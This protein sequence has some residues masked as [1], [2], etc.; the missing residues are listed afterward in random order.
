MAVQ[1]AGLSSLKI[2]FGYGVETTAG[3]K[4]ASFK[5]LERCNN[6]GGIELPVETID[7]SALEDEVTKYIAGRQDTGK[8]L[9]A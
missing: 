4:P 7:A 6:I 3:E 9:A 5:W 1:T 8:K 2:K